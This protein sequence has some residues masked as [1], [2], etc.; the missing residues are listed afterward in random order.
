MTPA[1][2]R[3]RRILLHLRD[4][5]RVPVEPDEVFLLEPP[6]NRV[7]PIARGRLATLWEAYGAAPEA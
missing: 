1:S 3:P 2:S 7:L 5:R 4:G 6:V